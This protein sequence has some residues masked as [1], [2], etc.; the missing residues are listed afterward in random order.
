MRLSSAP[1][2]RP[3]AAPPARPAGRVVAPLSGPS[4]HG[5]PRAR[6]LVAS[7]AGADDGDSSGSDVELSGPPTLT[8][9]PSRAGAAGGGARNLTRPPP[10][11]R[12]NA[13]REGQLQGRG[14]RGG[15]RGGENGRENATG[16]ER[17]R[18][19]RLALC[20]R[21]PQLDRPAR[22]GAMRHNLSAGRA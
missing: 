6:N 1:S 13:A 20:L 2:L 21:L 22:A 12:V 14:G 4:P 19:R 3:G 10:T 9:R 11:P 7:A 15:G 8:G 5:P 18:R 16:Q 17:R